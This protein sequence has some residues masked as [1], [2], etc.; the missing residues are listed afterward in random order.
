[1][2]AAPPLPS[3]KNL[4]DSLMATK[5]PRP[6]QKILHPWHWVILPSLKMSSNC[7]LIH[8]SP[9]NSARYTWK[10]VRK[11][12]WSC[13]LNKEPVNQRLSL[14]FIFLLYETDSAL[15]LGTPAEMK[16]T[17]DGL[18]LLINS[19]CSF[20]LRILLPLKIKHKPDWPF[21]FTIML[22]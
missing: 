6:L 17:A 19:L 7:F 4:H 12:P 1:M 14:Y 8:C 13:R 10:P 22:K 15:K 18:P 16:V 9:W 11:S 5:H 2:A 3:N 21:R 20:R